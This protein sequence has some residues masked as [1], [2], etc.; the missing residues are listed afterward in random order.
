M[1][2]VRGVG[3]QGAGWTWREPRGPTV[4]TGGPGGWDRVNDEGQWGRSHFGDTRPGRQSE[5]SVVS[6]GP[7]V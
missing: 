2:E 1:E 7:R 5:R 4:D 3:R 6:G